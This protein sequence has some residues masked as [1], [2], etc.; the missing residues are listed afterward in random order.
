M[1][2]KVLVR[3]CPQ[4]PED[5]VQV[6]PPLLTDLLCPV[7]VPRFDHHRQLVGLLEEKQPQAIIAAT[8]RDPGLA[9]GVYPFPLIEDGDFD[10]PSVYMKDVDGVRLAA[11]A[12]QEVKLVSVAHRMPAQGYNI[13]ARRGNDPHQ[14]IVIF[15]HI[16]AK[17]DTAGALDNGTGVVVLLLLGELLKDYA[18]DLTIELVA[19]NGEDY[20]AA[21]GE[22]LWIESNAERF[23]A[24]T[25]GINIDA[26]GYKQGKTAFSLYGCP[27]EID[28][29]IRKVFAARP[30]ITEGE[31][32]Y[33]SDHSLFIQNGAPALAITSEHFME[34]S[35]YVTHTPKDSPELVDYDKVVEIALA[36]RDLAL[37][38]ARP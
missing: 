38:L 3:R 35:T 19:L 28:Q 24:I 16:D 1:V 33:Q 18:G 2:V 11:F 13:T 17:E 14:R 15:G 36:L 5:G 10:I 29:S 30:G 21:P 6:L 22:I 4:M 8:A 32:W 27:P 34:L 31:A 9:G 12:G 25:L 20:Y 7:D 37:E 26:A 23:P